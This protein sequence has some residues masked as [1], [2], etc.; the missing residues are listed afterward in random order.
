MMVV[1]GMTFGGP[2]VF[3]DLLLDPMLVP[4]IQN[5]RGCPYK[6]RFCVS[7]T[8]LGKIRNF[9]FERVKEEITFLR[10]NAK[11]SFLMSFTSH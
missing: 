7:G 3:D 1:N 6:C 5:I 8:Q 9:S 4:I 11:N 10:L 2:T